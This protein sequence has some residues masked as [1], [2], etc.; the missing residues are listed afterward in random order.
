MSK[1]VKTIAWICLVLGLLGMAVEVGVY[2]RARS[3]MAQF[4]ESVK[5]GEFPM[6]KGR[7]T[8]GDGDF[9]KENREES[10]FDRS[11][12]FAHGGMMDGRRGFEPFSN[13]RG[14]FLNMHDGSVGR[15]SFAIPFLLL[16]SGPVLTV[17]GAVMLIVNREPKVDETKGKKAKSKKK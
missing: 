13:K 8:D 9:D 14:Y 12:W 7:F 4:Q 2:V 11:E 5:A 17:V 6:L 15:V 3:L 1:T 16:A 10:D